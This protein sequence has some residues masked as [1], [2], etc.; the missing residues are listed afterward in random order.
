MTGLFIGY[1]QIIIFKRKLTQLAT[2]YGVSMSKFYLNTYLETRFFFWG[3]A[4]KESE[5]NLKC[6][7]NVVLHAK[8]KFSIVRVKCL[9]IFIKRTTEPEMADVQR[10]LEFAVI[11]WMFIK[12]IVVWLISL[13]VKWD[14]LITV[15]FSCNSII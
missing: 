15:T 3:T 6:K 5:E 10:L 8:L 14:Q 12:F 11:R 4:H 2:L 1:W 7:Y 13:Q 9:Q